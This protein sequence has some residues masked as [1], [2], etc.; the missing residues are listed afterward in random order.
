MYF[1]THVSQSEIYGKRYKTLTLDVPKLNCNYRYERSIQLCKG[2][3]NNKEKTRK[4]TAMWNKEDKVT[5]RKP[6]RM[7]NAFVYCIR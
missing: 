1:S 2:L 4:Q 7:K 6:R 3:P 5:S